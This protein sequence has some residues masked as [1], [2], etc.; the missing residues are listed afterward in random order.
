MAGLDGAEM[1]HKLRCIVCDACGVSV[2]VRTGDDM[3]AERIV[4]RRKW[5][6]PILS[7]YGGT[8]HYCPNESCQKKAEEARYKGND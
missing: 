2:T 4:E 5:A 8:G 1:I 3:E 6:C 7:Y